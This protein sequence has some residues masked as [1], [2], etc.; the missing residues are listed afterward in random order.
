MKR[1]LC[2]AAAA[3]LTIT[4]T[5]SAQ[6]AVFVVRHAERADAAANDSPMMAS[7]PDLSAIGK[8]RATS[9]VTTLSDA[10]ISAIYST[11]YKRT[12]QTAEPLAKALGIAVTTVPARDMPALIEKLK[13][14]K[15]NALVVGHSNTVGPVIAGLGVTEKVE[16]TDS[17]YDNL[18]IVVR[19]ATP[20]LVR[21]HF[22]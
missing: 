20:S 19:S 4:A 12:Q 22:R 21:L 17:D 14:G 10:G 1:A 7:D 5:A 15:G 9:L 3:V 18:F 6:N 16:L 11:E 2:L 13:A 8:A